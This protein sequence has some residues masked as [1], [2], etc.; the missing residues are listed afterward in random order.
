MVNLLIER[1]GNS[2]NKEIFPYGGMHLNVKAIIPAKI[3]TQNVQDIL[4]L[5]P[6]QKSMIFVKL[7]YPSGDFYYEQQKYRL[8]GHI[9]ID[10]VE[11][12]WN[13]V[14]CNN[15]ML[16]TVFR[17]EGLE[18]PIQI[19]LK[20]IRILFKYFDFSQKS[21]DFSSTDDLENRLWR[22]KVD[23]SSQPFR[24]ILCKLSET[25][26][27]MIIS[28]HH[29]ILDGWSNAILL[30]E[31]IE[32][33]CSILY[34]RE[35]DKK[36]KTRHREYIKWMLKQDKLKAME[37]WKRYLMGYLESEGVVDISKNLS[38]QYKTC[39]HSYI[40]DIGHIQELRRFAQYNEITLAALFYSVWGLMQMKS[41][42]EYDVI[43][44][45]TVSGRDPELKGIDEMVGV[46]IKTLP[47]RIKSEPGESVMDVV[48]QVNSELLLI[49]SN[50]NV[51]LSDLLPYGG[52]NGKNAMNTAVVVQNYP[53][54]KTLLSCS[55]NPIKLNLLSSR[56]TTN[57]DIVLG[58]KIFPDYIELE[59]CYNGTLFSM[60]EIQE[61]C[62]EYVSYID[63]IIGIFNNETRIA[64]HNIL[65]EYNRGMNKSEADSDDY[66][67]KLKR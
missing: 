22:D 23:I 32:A 61:L 64:L 17:W 29:I 19:I 56:Y 42:M 52:G 37:Y 39:I 53:L 66:T 67:N 49:E 55:E 54:E 2:F 5:N 1:A 47:M 6:M 51:H 46:F 41:Q 10:I 11:K 26:Y 12:A 18:S 21:E 25:E 20:E 48:R 13:F 50:Q 31:F 16:R 35:P 27:H 40:F 38:G 28:T 9:K 62:N 7:M 4:P 14:A 59:F 65:F 33:Y 44:G 45:I 57:F 30:K 43:F 8:T 3:P 58:V 15:E 63:T 24:V 60:G 34:G 36:V